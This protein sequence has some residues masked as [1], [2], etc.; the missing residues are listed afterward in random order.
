ML[1]SVRRSTNESIGNG[2]RGKEKDSR[3]LTPLERGSVLQVKHSVVFRSLSS[4]TINMSSWC[5]SS[6]RMCICSSSTERASSRQQQSTDTERT[7]LGEDN[8]R[9]RD[10]Q[11]QQL[12]ETEQEGDTIIAHL[13]AHK[14]P[15][16]EENE[17]EVNVKPV[18]NQ[19][20]Q[21]MQAAAEQQQQIDTRL[22]F[23]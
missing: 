15:S 10:K 1:P 22:S 17:N 5:S 14:Q 21:V 9:A 6:S 20:Q 13:A 4:P 8:G 3:L 16:R 11:Q 12:R 23:N 7:Q 19:Q 18:A 2:A